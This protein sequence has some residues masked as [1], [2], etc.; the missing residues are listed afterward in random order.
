[1]LVILILAGG[2]CLMAAEPEPRWVRDKNLE[3]PD[4]RYISGLGMGKGQEE[5]RDAALS[6]V[7]LYF[8]TTIEV[9]KKLITRYN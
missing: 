4:S 6:E 8:G 5:A 7:A 9:Q 1:M 2:A 3:Y